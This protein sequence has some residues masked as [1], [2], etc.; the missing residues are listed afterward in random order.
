MRMNQTVFA[1]P[2]DD[3]PL[4]K[5]IEYYY[6]QWEIVECDSVDDAA[7]LVIKKHADGFVTGVASASDYSEKYNLYICLFQTLRSLLLQ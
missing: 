4:E 7:N 5:H 2:K 1:V 6:P 3:L